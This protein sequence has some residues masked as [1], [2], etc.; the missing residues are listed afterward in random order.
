MNILMDYGGAIMPVLADM[1]SISP[2]LMM[3]PV[4]MLSLC[5]NAPSTTSVAVSAVIALANI[6]H[7]SGSGSYR[8]LYQ[9][10][11]ASLYLV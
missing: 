3:D 7:M 1:I 11:T 4:P 6:G 10:G 2:G 5:S 8:F 9:G